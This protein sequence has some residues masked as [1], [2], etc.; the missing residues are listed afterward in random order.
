MK[1]VSVRVPPS[2]RLLFVAGYFTLTGALLF[3]LVV[4]SVVIQGMFIQAETAL[5]ALTLGFRAV[6]ALVSALGLL[7]TGRAL[8]E[9]RRTGRWSALITVAAPVVTSLASPPWSGA[10]ISTSVVGLTLLFIVRKEL[11]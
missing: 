2:T 3:A 1:F 4:V 10:L 5:P 11:P 8:R 6:G 7:W 9:Q